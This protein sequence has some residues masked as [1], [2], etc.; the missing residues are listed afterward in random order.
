MA[1][2]IGLVAQQ[3][4]IQCLRNSFG[5]FLMVTGWLLW[6]KAS[7]LCSTEKDI[8]EGGFSHTC[9]VF[10]M[11]AKLSQTSLSTSQKI[12]APDSSAR[13][14]PQDCPCQLTVKDS[15]LN[16]KALKCRGLG[17]E[18]W[19]NCACHTGGFDFLARSI[20]RRLWPVVSRSLLATPNQ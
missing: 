7:R 5:L 13:A 15:I 4:W 8:G 11:K 10:I 9:S 12:S 1:A 17:R 14:V 20:S 2:D 6:L 19:D 3:C 18:L 16:F